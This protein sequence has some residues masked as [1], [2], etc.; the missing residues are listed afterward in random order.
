MPE[1]T[2]KNP[3][4]ARA[5]LILL[6]LGAIGV[7]A[8][9]HPAPAVAPLRTADTDFAAF[10]AVVGK[11]RAGSSYY[12]SMGSELRSRAYPTR[13][14]FNW[15]TPLHLRALSAASE[16]VGRA[17]LTALLVVLCLATMASVGRPFNLTWTASAV[18]QAGVLVLYTTPSLAFL[19]ETWSGVLVGISLCAYARRRSAIAVGLG[20]LALFIRELA[21]PYC[22]VCTII[23]AFKRRWWE[24]GAWVAGA[25]AYAAYYGWHLTQVWAER[26]PTDFSHSTWLAFGGLPFLQATI[27]WSGWLF[28]LPLP[29][30]AAALMLMVAGVANTCAPLQVRV[31]SVVFALFFLIAGHPF[32]HYWGLIVGPTWAIVYGYG[33]K[34]TAHAV[35]TAFGSPGSAD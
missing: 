13:D 35:K 8:L 4:K 28:V 12:P 5:V 27:H 24:V 34:T 23:A 31:S 21:A 11:L 17:V 14:V 29:F 10:Q 30:A 32:N 2:A 33:T 25:C 1:H 20:L 22:V 9:G 6:A 7:A 16:G 19:G 3:T 15:R 26:L 18:M